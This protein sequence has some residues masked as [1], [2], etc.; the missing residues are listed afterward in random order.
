MPA[1]PTPITMT[2]DRIAALRKTQEAHKYGHGHALV[3]S[4]G[5]GRTGA[6]RLAARAA[7]RAGAGLVT[8]GVP[9]AAQLEVAA[10][11]TAVMLMRVPDAEALDAALADGRI[12]ALCLGP[13][14]GVDRAAHLLPEALGAGQ[15]APRATLLDADA[16]TA[17]GQDAALFGLLHPQC[18][19]TPH[20]GEFARLFPDLADRAGRELS[21]GRA[22]AVADAARRAGCTV[23]LKG[24][25]TVIAA[26]DGALSVHAARGAMA[27]PWLATAGTGD[28]L[29][30]LIAGL[31]ARGLPPVAAA[32]GGTW[33]HAACAR[34]VG[35]GLIAED[36]PEALPA[37]YADLGV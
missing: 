29:A 14:L 25:D 18:V 28:V 12:N 13:G 16:L 1:T 23:L 33:L 31:M 15:A 5:A 8:L 35:P 11:I 24:A 9:P 2:P 6:A 32:Q 22:G 17:L 37:V 26:P 20:E 7:L 34:R 19:L 30:G 3:L 27:A 36:L 10:Q 4:G 21:D